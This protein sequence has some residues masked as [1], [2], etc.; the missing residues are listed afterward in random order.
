MTDEELLKAAAEAR[1]MAHEAPKSLDGSPSF[2]WAQWS[3]EWMRL[4]DEIDRR[5][6]SQHDSQQSAL[7]KL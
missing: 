7:R 4:M 2:A 1:C 6:L 3:R 5:G